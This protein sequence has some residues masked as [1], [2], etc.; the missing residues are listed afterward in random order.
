MGSLEVVGSRN[1]HTRAVSPI[2]VTV[3]DE[4][5]QSQ[6]ELDFSTPSPPPSPVTQKPKQIGHDRIK[7]IQYVR[8]DEE[9]VFDNAQIK[10]IE[11]NSSVSTTASKPTRGSSPI[12]G[13]KYQRASSFDQ[14]HSKP[15]SREPSPENSRSTSPSKK[16]PRSRAARLHSSPA[17]E[18]PKPQL[19]RR[20]NSVFSEPNDVSTAKLLGRHKSSFSD[21]EDDHKLDRKSMEMRGKSPSPERPSWGFGN[22]RVPS[23]QEVRDEYE[24]RTSRNRSRAPSRSQSRSQS[25][26]D[27]YTS[28][29]L[30]YDDVVQTS[31][32]SL[33]PARKLSRQDSR[34]SVLSN[35]SSRW[36]Q[37]LQNYQALKTTIYKNG[38]QWFDGFELRFRP[39]KDFQDLDA[40][41][42]KISPKIDFTTSVAYLFDTDGN[43][44]RKIDE[45]EDGQGYVA[46]NTRRFVPANY[47]RTGEAFWMEGR[48][49]SRV[50]PY[51]KRSGSSKSSGSDS[52]PGSGDGKVIKI[53]NNE[54]TALSEKV[55]LN[56]KTSQ[57]F[58]EVVRDL[59]QVLKIKGADRMYTTKGVEVKS[60]SHLRND[61]Y[62]DD[63]FV[64][65]AGPT[66]ISR[67]VS[68]LARTGSEP[69]LKS[70]AQSRSASRSKDLRE[71]DSA[72][73]IKILI[74]GARKIYHAPN[75]LPKDSSH[76][77]AKL[78]LEWVY[79]YRGADQNKNLWVLE[80][81]ELIYYVGAVAIIYNR[82]DEKQRH[83]RGHNEDIQCMDLHPLGEIV[84]SGQMG[85]KTPENAAH[86]RIWDVNTMDTLTVLGLGE[87]DK[88]ICGVSFSPLNKGH[89]VCAVDDSKEKI[90]AMW[91]WEKNDQLSKVSI[92]AESISGISFHPFDNN[93]VITHGKAHLAFW[94][95]KKDGFFARSN[96][97]EPTPGIVYQCIAFLESGDLVTGDS[98]GNINSYSVSAEGEYFRSFSIPAH[99]KGVSSILAMAEGTILS[100]GDKDRKICAWDSARDF[101]MI[102]ETELPTTAG[103]GRTLY[104]QWPSR[105][106]G[107]V[108]VGTT[109]NLILE[110]S[111]QRKFNMVVYGHTKPVTALT[112][113]PSDVSFV[114]AGTDKVVAKWRRSKLIWKLTVQAE[115][116]SACHHPQGSVVAVG[117][118]DGHMIVISTDSGSHVTT[119]RICGSALNGLKFNLDGDVVA[120]ASQNGSIYL[121]KASRDGFAYKKYGKIS[122]G[123]MLTHIDWDNEGE[124]LQT[125]SADFNLNFW[126]SETNKLE[127]VPSVLRNKE[128]VDQ[129]CVVGWSVAG[130]WSNHN[131]QNVANIE[132]AHVSKFRE[133]LVAGDSDGY[134]RLFGFPCMNPKAEFHEEKAVSGPLS[135]ARFFYD[136]SYV[137]AVGGLE[138]AIF[139]FKIK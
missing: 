66:R 59:G 1:G 54:D 73:N 68:K 130:L 101:I 55:L 128:W 16:E 58:E 102:A 51:R 44:V 29:G 103:S 83:Y 100:A 63:V 76:P 71:T 86:I 2:R 124:Y 91:D 90:L 49:Y 26:S 132:T 30:S 92:E 53:V 22:S 137:I 11:K 123:Q 131:Y 99:T 36:K 65:S 120:G 122:G 38:D 85:G 126:N 125:A 67:S 20:R 116:A 111:L 138:A 32:N 19:R 43:R 39:S 69:T 17:E 31:G 21:S 98:D 57:T 27:L 112:T 62:N 93:L 33:A 97:A 75:T 129:T 35:I 88:G 84:V 24:G 18:R 9:D 105:N 104:P 56:L 133:L 37:D 109:K 119:I 94:N 79:G 74:N 14:E 3:T 115:C 89:Y 118:T 87:C 61:F 70:R 81:G 28:A 127:K 5:T 52:K 78:A 6:V 82:M 45:L 77:G 25:R 34:I 110:G 107:N 8:K 95:R 41:L 40:L 50:G 4:D 42:S 46:S 117:T 134:L 7:Q 139:K 106:D 135:C 72:G 12:G 13:R 80:K 23:R 114:T 113:H 60:F 121:Y 108:Y 15:P 10:H 48:R 47:G 64:I 136:D 96:V